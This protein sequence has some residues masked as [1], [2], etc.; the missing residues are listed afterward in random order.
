MVY[1]RRRGA[2]T[3][4]ALCVSDL[5]QDKTHPTSIEYWFR[6]LDMDGDGVISMHELQVFYDEQVTDL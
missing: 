5:A 4:H 6:V 2:T 1:T 3:C